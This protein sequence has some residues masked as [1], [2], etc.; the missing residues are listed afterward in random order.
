MTSEWQVRC[1]GDMSGAHVCEVGPGP[2]GL[3][4]EI[5]THDI[6][7]LSVI[8]KDERFLPLLQVHLHLTITIHNKSPCLMGEMRQW[9][10]IGN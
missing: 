3:T 7:Q 2:G 6:K 10:Y 4:R 5:L 9:S 1:A 8:E